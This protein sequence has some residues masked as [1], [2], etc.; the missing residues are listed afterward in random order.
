LSESILHLT[1][2]LACPLR[3][4]RHIPPTRWQAGLHPLFQ[5]DQIMRVATLSIR[6]PD[7]VLLLIDPPAEIGTTLEPGATLSVNFFPRLWP[8]QSGCRAASA[9]LR[10]RADGKFHLPYPWVYRALIVNGLIC[11]N[12]SS[13]TSHHPGWLAGLPA[14]LSLFRA[15]GACYSLARPLGYWF[16]PTFWMMASSGHPE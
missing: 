13:G 16:G 10:T 2:H 15:G 8:D 5:V 7:L 1:T 3:N 12:S 14:G 9:R 11:S 6:Q 4:P